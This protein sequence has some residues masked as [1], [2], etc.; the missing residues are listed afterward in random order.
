MK[1]YHLDSSII[2]SLD[3]PTASFTEKTVE[4]T[5]TDGYTIPSVKVAQSDGF[6]GLGQVRFVCFT[7][8]QH[9]FSYI[10]AVI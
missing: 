10:M 3:T 5:G 4:S 1:Y 6:D 9:Y 7:P 8:K 2:M